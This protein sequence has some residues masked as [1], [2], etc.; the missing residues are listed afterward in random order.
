MNSI[1]RIVSLLIL[2][3]FVLCTKVDFNNPLDPSGAYDPDMARDEDGN[4]VADY[5][6]DDDGDKVI[7]GK[8]P[9]WKNYIKDTV[10]PKFSM[11]GGDEVKVNR[12][13]EDVLKKYTEFK[14]QV[15][16]EDAKDGDVT[17][18]ITIYPP[19]VS[20]LVDE[21]YSVI[22]I[23]TDI[24][25]N[26]DTIQRTFIVYTPVEIDTV[27]PRIFISPQLDTI[28]YN[29][30]D[31]Y[32]EPTVSAFDVVDGDVT[33]S[34]KKTGA[35]NMDKVGVYPIEYTATDSS[36]NSTKKTIYIN[37]SPETSEDRIYPVITLIGGDT[38][39]LENGAAWVEPG[40]TASDNKDGDITS[41]VS[42]D[43]GSI[44]GSNRTNILCKVMYHVTD[45]AKNSASASRFVLFGTIE[46]D[47]PP[48]FYL[49]GKL[50]SGETSYSLNLK[51]RTKTITAIDKDDKDI[52]SDIKRSGDFDSAKTGSYV[53]TYSVKD[54]N[55]VEATL[56]VT[57]TVVDPNKDTTKPVIKIKGNNPDTVNVDSEKEYADAGATATD[58]VNG[59]KDT[60]DVT[61]EGTVNLKVAGTYKITYTAVDGAGN[62]A[63]AVRTVVARD[64]SGN[65]LL[66]YGVP[67]KAPLATVNQEYTSFSIDGDGPAFSDIKSMSIDWS[68]TE[69]YKNLNSFSI[70]TKSN[71]YINLMTSTNTFKSASPLVTFTG[72][73]LAD[74]KGTF[75]VTVI[76]D[77]M[78]WVE[79]NGEYAIVWKQ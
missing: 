41:K 65:L 66:K 52:S 7:N 10:P 71:Q 68:Y 64:V 47:I 22:F 53:L 19:E 57:I 32:N 40:Y 78:I 5:F 34:I 73:G 30:G 21:I 79:E 3:L 13:T 77:E 55:F 18:R 31:S 6:E 20:T 29:L 33:S 26:A 62:E 76:D 11:K 69:Y 8:D 46:V 51:S 42:V 59:R 15:K 36:G 75:W 24:D 39:K 9:D 67:G 48:S 28:P 45:N 44:T 61:A 14:N 50:I 23:V 4:G 54:K 58:V 49:D 43:S 17:N 72:T 2:G 74:L 27:G 37:V 16:A 63:T 35:P 60:L 25:N 1:I 38:I 56:K 70:N 12:S